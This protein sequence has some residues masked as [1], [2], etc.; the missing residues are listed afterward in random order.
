M[1][2]DLRLVL[3]V[4][5]QVIWMVSDVTDNQLMKPLLLSTVEHKLVYGFSEESL[6]ESALDVLGVTLIEY[7]NVVIL[8]KQPEYLRVGLRAL[9]P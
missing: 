3:W 1:G 7:L 9:I 8:L 2:Q 5:V 4:R 6:P